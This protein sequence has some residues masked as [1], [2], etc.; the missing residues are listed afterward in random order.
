MIEDRT[1]D[2]SGPGYGASALTARPAR[3]FP[4]QLVKGFMGC[5]RRMATITDRSS[6]VPGRCPIAAKTIGHQVEK[7]RGSWTFSHV[8][9]HLRGVPAMATIENPPQ[10]LMGI[11]NESTSSINKVGCAASIV[12][13]ITDGV[14]FE[15]GKARGTSFAMRAN[16]VVFPQRFSGDSKASR[17]SISKQSSA[18]A[19]KIQRAMASAACGGNTT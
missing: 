6:I 13:K 3:R 11:G 9:D 16:K 18:C 15:V 19:R 2:A 14:T 4:P 7:E 1:R 10:F 8:P 12:R 17:G 5:P